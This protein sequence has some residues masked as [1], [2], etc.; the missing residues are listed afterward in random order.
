MEM[1]ID[2]IAFIPQMGDMHGMHPG[3]SMVSCAFVQGEGCF[4]AGDGWGGIRS[5]EN[6]HDI[7]A[8]GDAIPQ[9]A[10]PIARAAA[11]QPALAAIDG[12]G[13][14]TVFRVDGALHLNKYENIALSANDI[15]LAGVSVAEVVPQYFCPMSAQPGGGNQLG[16]FTP[17]AHRGRGIRIPGAAPSVQQVQTSGDDVP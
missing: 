8:Y 10:K 15:H 12:A 6:F 9:E 16:V 1:T 17:V 5:Q 13:W 14:G 11:Q 4:A 7:E 2:F 3:K